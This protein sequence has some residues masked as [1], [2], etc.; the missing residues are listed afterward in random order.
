MR[1][2]VAQ[3]PSE[4]GRTVIRG[5]ARA[6]PMPLVV[7][8]RGVNVGKKRFSTL[9]LAKELADVEATSIG[10]AGTFVVRGRATQASLKKRIG[11]WLPFE[12]EVLVLPGADVARAVEKGRD[13]PVPAGAKRFATA[14][15]KKPAKRPKLPWDTPETGWGVRI[16]ALDGR[17][18]LGL[19]RSVAATG[20]Y[21]NEVVEKGLGVK[22]TTR[23][24]GT[25]E[26]VAAL[27]QG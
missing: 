15:A 24:W 9:A 16:A 6:P 5:A 17:F 25:M 12:C 2:A 7:L 19:R 8:L 14:L 10:A 1:F 18:A 22:A 26:K 4:G 23:D 21:P 20:W 3:L 13:I 27:V 11:E